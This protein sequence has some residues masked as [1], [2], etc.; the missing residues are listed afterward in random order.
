MGGTGSG[1]TGIDAAG[2]ASTCGQPSDTRRSPWPLV[3]SGSKE[4][5]TAATGVAG[6]ATAVAF[7]LPS[8]T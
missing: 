8:D 7:G 5:G 1:E 3:A 2:T 6:G 4:P